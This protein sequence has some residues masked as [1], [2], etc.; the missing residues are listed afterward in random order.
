MS[1][2]ATIN[3]A[4]NCVIDIDYTRDEDADEDE[5]ANIKILVTH[6][7][8]QYFFEIGYE[9][10]YDA[11]IRTFMEC[12]SSERVLYLH[13]YNGGPAIYIKKDHVRLELN[14]H[15]AGFHVILPLIEENFIDNYGKN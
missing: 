11:E 2:I 9:D 4:S 10:K 12:D 14:N 5:Y 3:I 1:H 7:S 15:G 13:V 8:N 6:N